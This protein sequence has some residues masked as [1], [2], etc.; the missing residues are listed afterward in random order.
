MTEWLAYTIASMEVFFGDRR[1]RTI[2]G[3]ITR[4]PGDAIV[5]AAN[6]ALQGGGGL[7]GAIHRTGGPKIMEDLDRIRAAQGKCDV[8]EAVITR[9]GDLPAKFV[10]HTVG[11][12]WREGARGLDELLASCYHRCLQMAEARGLRIVNFP[13]I[14]TGAFHYPLLEA[15]DV[16]ME[17]VVNYLL[18]TQGSLETVTFVLFDDDTLHAYAAALRRRMPLD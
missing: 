11:P 1:V 12:S 17:T 6:S 13:S 4:V 2:K 10:I 3:D 7:D 14:S 18:R 5:T 15:A 16:A 8:G 9:A